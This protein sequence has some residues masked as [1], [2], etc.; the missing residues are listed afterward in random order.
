MGKKIIIT[1]GGTK[2]ELDAVRVVTNKS[3]G[4]MGKALEKAAQNMGADV[5]YI[6]A[7]SVDQLK[8][9]IENNYKDADALIMAAAVS[10]YR[11]LVKAEGKIKSNNQNMAIYC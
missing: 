7:T 10:D 4:K 8:R 5:T 9:E 6:E 2:E 1:G 11:P 3:S